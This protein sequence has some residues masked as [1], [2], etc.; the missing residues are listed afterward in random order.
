MVVAPLRVTL[1]K[2]FL[3]KKD[4]FP[5]PKCNKKK[6]LICDSETS[7]NLKIP[8]NS[9]NVGYILKCDTCAQKGE[10]RI[11]EGET[12]RSA[13]TRGQEHLRGL[14][15]G[16]EDCSIFKHKQNEHKDEE[17]KIKMEITKKFKDPLTRQANE[18]VRIS[19]RSKSELLNSKSEFN[20]P[21]TARIVVE[22]RKNK[23]QNKTNHQINHA[24][25]DS[26]HSGIEE[27]FRSQ[28]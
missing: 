21:P 23:F 14:M 12:S 11:Y 10:I 9:N 17:M 28:M 25:L 24:A 1:L 5:N 27:L 7:E 15:K 19:N 4:L 6:C 26:F 16:K 20:H 13:R 18:S 2:D 8:C 22:R 3:I